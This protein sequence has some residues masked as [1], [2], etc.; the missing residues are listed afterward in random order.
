MS[1]PYARVTV[2]AQDVAVLRTGAPC[3]YLKNDVA[4]DLVFR[5]ILRKWPHYKSH[6]NAN[7]CNHALGI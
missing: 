5:R 4:H 1:L 6:A 3:L 2:S 7:T